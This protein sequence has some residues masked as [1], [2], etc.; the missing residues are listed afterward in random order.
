MSSSCRLL[1]FI[2]L[3]KHMDLTLTTELEAVNV[4]LQTIGETPVNSLLVTGLA[5]VSIAINTLREASREVQTLGWEFN[6]EVMT[7]TPDIDGNIHI[8]E[9]ALKIDPVDPTLHYVRRGS[10]LYDKI[11]NTHEFTAPVQLEIV[12]F[13]DFEDMPEPARR[14]IT[15]KAARRFQNRVLGAEE[16][17]HYTKEDELEAKVALQEYELE[18]GE[19]NMLKSNTSFIGLMSR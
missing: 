16:V 8:P 7:L 9:T 2:L 1:F 18:T 10:L 12:W 11:R 4:M 5:D 17:Y 14:Y 19:Y 15:I 3:E 6:T 13:L